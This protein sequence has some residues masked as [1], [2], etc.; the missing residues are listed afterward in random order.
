VT[1]YAENTSV[2]SEKSRGEIERTLTRYGADQF[3]Y[4]WKDAAAVI[5]FRAKGR[6][7]R[8][9]LPMPDRMSRTITHTPGRGIARGPA[10][11]E[12]AYEQA[13]R[14]RWRALALCIK[15]KLEA[16][17]AGITDFEDEFMAQI[18]LPNGQSMSEH[19]KPLIARAYDTG[20]MPPLLPH[21]GS[22][23]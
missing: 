15:A 10:E 3:M 23:E 4:G 5:A 18:I 9:F 6:H 2:P 13:V 1:K 8:F 19:A 16:V 14:Q 22:D 12:A 21:L 20:K 7:I 17:E 11:R